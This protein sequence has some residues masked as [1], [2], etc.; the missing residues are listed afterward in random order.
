MNFLSGKYRPYLLPVI[1]NVDDGRPATEAVSAIGP[2]F[3]VDFIMAK[4]LPCHAL[5]CG[6]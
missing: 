3:S 6:N 2:S 4:H 5:R 1:N